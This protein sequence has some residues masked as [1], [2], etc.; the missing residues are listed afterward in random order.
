MG[1][2]S[3]PDPALSQAEADSAASQLA[4]LGASQSAGALSLRAAR[5][6]AEAR[7]VRLDAYGAATHAQQRLDRL[8][9]LATAA[10]PA[11]EESIGG[12]PM[13][14]LGSGEFMEAWVR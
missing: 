7:D 3:D 4:S 12:D 1:G 13:G 5:L 2:R 8:A 10:A 14:A 9:Y 11:M 6:A